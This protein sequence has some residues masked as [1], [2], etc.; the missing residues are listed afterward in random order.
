MSVIVRRIREKP[1]KQQ[2]AKMLAVEIQREKERQH[3]VMVLQGLCALVTAAA[4]LAGAWTF[5]VVCAA[6]T[7]GLFKMESG[8]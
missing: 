2:E 1:M 5:A 7:W 4:A 8:R 3:G 6:C